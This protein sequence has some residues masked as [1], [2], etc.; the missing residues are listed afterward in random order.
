MT[1][2]EDLCGSCVIEDHHHHPRGS[3]CSMQGCKCEWRSGQAR[4]ERSLLVSLSI[5]DVAASFHFLDRHHTGDAA[6]CVTCR[7]RAEAFVTLMQLRNPQRMGFYTASPVAEHKDWLI[8]A[9]RNAAPGSPWHALIDIATAL[10]ANGMAEPSLALAWTIVTMMGEPDLDDQ[11]VKGTAKPSVHRA[12]HD[13]HP[14][15]KCRYAGQ[16]PW[17]DL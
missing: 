13:L 8:E 2:F 15:A 6:D 14:G 10:E 9:L 17:A 1:A 12:W 11:P 3:R 5:E 7:R 4:V 16:R